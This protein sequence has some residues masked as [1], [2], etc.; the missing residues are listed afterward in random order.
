[1]EDMKLIKRIGC[2]GYEVVPLAQKSG[3]VV[4][5]FKQLYELYRQGVKAPEIAQQLGV[6]DYLVYKYI[7]KFKIDRSINKAMFMLEDFTRPVPKVFGNRFQDFLEY[8]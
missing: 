1:M 6:S 2:K 4:F 3:V 5:E 8:T 7:K